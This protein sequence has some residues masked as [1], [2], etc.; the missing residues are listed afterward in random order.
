ML[1]GLHDAWMLSPSRSVYAPL[2]NAGISDDENVISSESYVR[3]PLNPNC[4]GEAGE[5]G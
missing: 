5:S 3:W 4:E 2:V 1:S